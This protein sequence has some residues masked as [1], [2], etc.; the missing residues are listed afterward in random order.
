MPYHGTKQLS[1]VHAN[2][3]TY[4]IFGHAADNR[5]RLEVV[6]VYLVL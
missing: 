5:D 1:F 6:Y 2:I 4:R 3:D